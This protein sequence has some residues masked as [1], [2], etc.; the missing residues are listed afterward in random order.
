MFY[1]ILLLFCF[2]LVLPFILNKFFG[3]KCVKGGLN[4]KPNS[5]KP[6]AFERYAEISKPEKCNILNDF[7]K[8]QQISIKE[9]TGTSERIL[10]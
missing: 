6:T 2:A 7:M 1:L 9:C 3:L 8:Q 5:P 10:L 4:E